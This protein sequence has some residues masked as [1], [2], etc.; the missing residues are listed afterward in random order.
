MNLFILFALLLLVTIYFY[1]TK[2]VR[3]ILTDIR[4]IDN[5]LEFLVT[6]IGYN[7]PK[8]EGNF[9]IFKPS[10]Y[11]VVMYTFRSIKCYID[12]NSV[13][14]TGNF[15]AIVKLLKMIKSYGNAKSVR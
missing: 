7:R 10:V 13:V 12:G 4:E 1:S 14:I 5:V 3:I 2:S 15:M 11:Q 6:Q 9:L 8:R